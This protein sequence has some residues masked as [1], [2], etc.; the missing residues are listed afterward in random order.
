[1]KGSID[2]GILYGDGTIGELGVVEGYV[3]SDY[4]GSA[5]TRKSLIGN[6]FT[7]F[8]GTISWKL[9]FNPWWLYP[10]QKLNM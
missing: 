2:V 6:V 5:D 7:L 9:V 4:A 3:D 8:G 1:M 10:R